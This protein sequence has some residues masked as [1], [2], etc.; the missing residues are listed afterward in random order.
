[1]ELELI[2]LVV[3]PTWRSFSCLFFGAAGLVAVP[4]LLAVKIGISFPAG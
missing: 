4:V 3:R 2:T 1:M